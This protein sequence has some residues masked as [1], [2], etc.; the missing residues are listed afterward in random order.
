MRTMIPF[1]VTP[2]RLVDGTEMFE[3][4][5]ATL[6]LS[7]EDADS[8]YRHIRLQCVSYRWAVVLIHVAYIST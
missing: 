5:A 3:K 8:R 2:C 1:E 7:V 4:H 6:F